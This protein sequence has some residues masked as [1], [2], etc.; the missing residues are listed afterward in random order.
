M[1]LKQLTIFVENKKGAL[2]EVD[3]TVD[4]EDVFNAI[5][6]ILGA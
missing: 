5:V 6:K 1:S 3:G 4:M 2:V